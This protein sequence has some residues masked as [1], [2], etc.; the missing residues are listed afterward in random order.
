MTPIGIPHRTWG[1]PLRALK[2][3]LA[4]LGRSD[5]PWGVLESAWVVFATILEL[6]IG[7]RLSQ[8][9]TEWQLDEF[10]ALVDSRDD[11]TSEAWLDT[12]RPDYRAVV[13]EETGAIVSEAARWLDSSFGPPPPS[14]GG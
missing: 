3:E 13:R 8:G 4:M 11:A 1:D 7:R 14:T 12:H 5:I 6:R 9:L 10:T 2:I